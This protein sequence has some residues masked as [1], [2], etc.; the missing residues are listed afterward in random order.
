MPLWLNVILYINKSFVYENVHTILNT[1]TESF[2]T[3]YF[4]TLPLFDLQSLSMPFLCKALLD[5][6]LKLSLMLKSQRGLTSKKAIPFLVAY[7]S[8]SRVPTCRLNAR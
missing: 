6:S 4:K 1:T 3:V 2:G 5:N 7:V 8:A